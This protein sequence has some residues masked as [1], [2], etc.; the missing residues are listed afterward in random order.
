MAIVVPGFRFSAVSAGIRKDGR[1][2]VALAVADRPATVAGVFTRNLVRAAPVLIA[3]QRVR[4]GSARAVLV[5][6]GCANACTGEP[7]LLATREST[8]AVAR[9]LGIDEAGVLPA[10]TGVIGA[11]LPSARI[12]ERA[13]E[14]VAGLSADKSDDFATA[15]L[16]TDR[17][18]KT[19]TSA[20]SRGSKQATVFGVGKGAG[21]IH[22]DVGPPQATML[23]FLFTDARVEPR[24]LEKAL[25]LAADQTFNTCSVDGDTSTNDTVLAF[26]SGVSDLSFSAEELAPALIEVS[27]S[28]A[29]SMVADGEGANHE[30][31][32][33][34]RGLADASGARQIAKTVATSPLVKTALFGEDVNWGRIL[35]A[36]GR[37]GVPFDPNRAELAV[38]DVVIVRNGLAVGKDA[39]ERA[40]AVLRTKR[41]VITLT[42]GDGPGHARYLTSDLGHGYIDV[43]A[44]YRS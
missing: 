7:G 16:T 36:A 17:W 5:N 22:P 25:V 29:R 6:S 40:N 31:E 26:A 35:A 28:I 24:E 27:E 14:L 37:A 15:I 38:G 12:A 4:G 33:Q 20:L 43:N 30:A 18:P 11:V 32:L 42:L 41:Y 34:V 1:I 2:D 13:P 39:E 23:V 44:G 10:S 19:A 3:E 21:M 9:A 8:A